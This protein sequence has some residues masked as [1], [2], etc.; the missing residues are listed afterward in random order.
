M[1]QPRLEAWL[2][3]LVFWS[4]HMS[5]YVDANSLAQP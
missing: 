2:T 4:G 5:D 3:T 1:N